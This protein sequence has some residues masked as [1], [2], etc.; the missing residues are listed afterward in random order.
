MK[1]YPD[2]KKLLLRQGQQLWHLHYAL[3][4][5]PEEEMI[6]EL[7]RTYKEVGRVKTVAEGVVLAGANITA[8][9]NH[10]GQK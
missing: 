2:E 5:N 9:P 4:E 1:N 10:A 3:Q 8:Y 7:V 6:C